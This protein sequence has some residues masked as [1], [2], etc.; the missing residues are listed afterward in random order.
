MPQ[1]ESNALVLYSQNYKEQDKLVKI[2]TKEHGK[3]MFFLKNPSK[4]RL[5]FGIQPLTSANMIFQINDTGFSFINDISEV[6][7]FKNINEDIFLNAH[8]SYLVALAD[9]SISD[10]IKDIPLFEFLTKSLELIDSGFDREVITNIFELQ[11]MGHFGSSIDFSQCVFCHRTD[12]PMDYSF[13]YN[14]CLCVNHFNEDERRSH[15]DP[16]VIYFANLFMHVDLNKIQNISLK[17]DLKKKIR[18]FVDELYEEYVGIHL[19][20]KKF[21]DQMD[22]WSN[23]MTDLGHARKSEEND[24]ES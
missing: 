13:K 19:K 20:P 7:I 15:L 5:N 2:F 9:A 16:N 8:A 24:K 22:S 18:L 17:D 10:N 1:M 6:K 14:G 3:R 23:L 4:S 12:L 21:L 11:I